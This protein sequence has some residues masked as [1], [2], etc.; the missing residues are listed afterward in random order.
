MR[1]L[2]VAAAAA[3]GVGAGGGPARADF[4]LLGQFDSGLPTPV[5]LGFDPGTDRVWVY[6]DFASTLRSYSRTGA[7]L[8]SVARPGESANDADITFAPEALT[9]GGTS[10]AA[11]SL[12]FINGETDAAE[13][14]AV[15][16]DTGAVLATLNTA[17]GLDHVVGGAYH[18]GR[19][20]FFL[21][22]DR[23]PAGTVND[24]VVAEVNAATGA[25][26]NTFQI[27]ALLPGFTVNFG[28][29]E[30]GANG[31]LFVVSSDEGTVAE[32]TP[33]GAFVRQ[34]TLPAGV[35]S[36]SGLGFDAGRNEVWV[37]GTGGTVWRLGGPA[38]AVPEPGSMALGGLGVASA[39]AYRRWWGRHGRGRAAG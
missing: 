4:M 13:I 14:Y 35:S 21:V 9:L 27:T 15:D 26:L 7:F 12:L 18:P 30:V 19:D 34:H 36:L 38:T 39:L 1:A 29:L 32:F 5:S 22:Q 28:D 2:L 6:D 11:G 17:F 37:T 8:S 31:N 10:V 3:V 24:S 20:T 23:V 16:K 25:V 33:G